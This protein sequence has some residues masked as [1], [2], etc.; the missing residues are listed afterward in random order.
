[1]MSLGQPWMRSI[2]P[3]LSYDAK[4]PATSRDCI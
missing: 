2:N 4:A 1:M 3:K